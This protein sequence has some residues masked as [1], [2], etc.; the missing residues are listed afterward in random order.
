MTAHMPILQ[1]ILPL[2]AAPLCVMLRRG[3][4]AW[5][6]CL[7]VS[8]LSFFV[9]IFLLSRTLDG[10]I[11]SYH[12]GSW[13]PPWGIEFRIDAVNAF[14]LLIISG[15]A[16]IVLPYARRSVLVEIPADQ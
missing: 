11:L 1:V 7:V 16:A 3:T 2:I 13:P 14:V 9:A 15:V 10:A 5:L 4:W 6:L 8:W 12:L